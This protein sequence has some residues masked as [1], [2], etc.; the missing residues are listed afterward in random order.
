M[1]KL[2]KTFALLV[3]AVAA[4]FVTSCSKEKPIEPAKQVAVVDSL[5][6]QA[7]YTVRSVT[8]NDY[9]MLNILSGQV[10]SN[11]PSPVII[12]I[13]VNQ[14]DATE[15]QSRASSMYPKDNGTTQKMNFIKIDKDKCSVSFM[16]EWDMNAGEY[17]NQYPNPNPIP[18][19]LLQQNVFDWH[20]DNN[21][22]YTW[23]TL[24]PG[25]LS[26]IYTVEEMKTGNTTTGYKLT[27]TEGTNKEIVIELDK[28]L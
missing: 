26:G 27:Y 13:S 3:V 1:K 25:K 6:N 16:N 22:S 2:F 9:N 17:S 19:S 7:K 11:S 21:G 15:T 10:G 12:E 14:L 20:S 24:R 18:Q 5:E 28:E 4:L 23:L 8:Y